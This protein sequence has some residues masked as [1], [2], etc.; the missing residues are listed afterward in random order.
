M[1]QEQADVTELFNVEI[2]PKI[3]FHTTRA[4]GL[5]KGSIFVW[6]GSMWE[7]VEEADADYYIQA[8]RIAQ[9]W[10]NNPNDRWMA[11][12]GTQPERFNG[13]CSVIQLMYV[14]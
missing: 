2:E 14:R 3:R 10:T 6:Q 4:G 11:T 7:V 5:L 9:G 8:K 13:Y 1:S 12:S